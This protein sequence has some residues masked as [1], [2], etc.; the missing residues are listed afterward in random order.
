MTRPPSQQPSCVH[1]QTLHLVRRLVAETP[2]C[3][4]LIS[5]IKLKYFFP[6][7]VAKKCAD[8]RLGHTPPSPDRVGCKHVEVVVN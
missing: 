4:G 2:Y 6:S 8:A 3:Q 5:A 1:A 7:G